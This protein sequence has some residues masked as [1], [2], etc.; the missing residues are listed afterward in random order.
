LIKTIA[1]AII[2][3]LLLLVSDTVASAQTAAAVT[4]AAMTK[5]YENSQYGV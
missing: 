2:P 3:L 4:A 5:I 1:F